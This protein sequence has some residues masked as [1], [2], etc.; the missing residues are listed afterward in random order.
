MV[1]PDAL[2][3]LSGAD[4][5]Q[6]TDSQTGILLQRETEADDAMRELMTLV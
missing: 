4:W 6:L 2:S 5:S 1:L 3:R